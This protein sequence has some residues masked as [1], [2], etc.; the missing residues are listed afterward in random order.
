MRPCSRRAIRGVAA[1]PGSARLV[2]RG[3]TALLCVTVGAMLWLIGSFTQPVFGA[4]TNVQTNTVSATGTDTSVAGTKFTDTFGPFAPGNTTIRH[5]SL[6]NTGPANSLA[7]SSLR[8]SAAAGTPTGGSGT[9][10]QFTDGI[11]VSIDY[12]IGTYS[13][14][15]NSCSGSWSTAGV[16]NTKLSGV[17][18]L[19][20]LATV[21]VP[22]ANNG[23]VGLRFTYA[24]CTGASTPNVGCTALA[25][26]AI[27]S[28]T[29]PVTWTFQTSQRAGTTQ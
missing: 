29:L 5:V 13:T 12:C 15:D 24:V 26:T 22:A 4:W 18:T 1:V 10:P 19:S 8:V 6:T 11:T 16:A 17:T 14:T 9:A 23:S 20:A 28:T 27:Q 3:C 21:P 2:A 25:N 7:A